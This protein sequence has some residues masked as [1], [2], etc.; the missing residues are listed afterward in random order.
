[1][2]KMRKLHILSLLLFSV[3]ISFA[4]ET[5]KDTLKTEVISV[6]KP[7]TPTISDAFKVT[8][9]PIIDGTNSFQKEKV[10]YTIFSIPVA[11]TFTPAKGTAQTV[12]RA[13]KERLYEN[14][15]SAG[16][17]NYTSPLFD[18]FVHYGDPKY[19]DFGVF[20]NYFSS[21]GGIKD[22][23]LN[24]NFSNA[25]ADIYY[26][27][28]ERGFDWK[29]NA[30]YKR[31]QTNYYGLPTDVIYD[32][33][34]L[35]SIDEKQVYNTIYF[36]GDINFDDSIFQ[37]G[38]IEFMNF[39][40]YYDSNE[41]RFFAKSNLEYP[42][43]T[44]IIKGEIL[45]DYV[46]GKFMHNY[47]NP[48]PI[49]YSF[50]TI[51]ANPSFEVLRTNLSVNLGVKL[52]YTFDM[53]NS[54]NQF[55]AYPNVTAS[56]QVVEDIFIVMAGV[57]GDLI[58][59][60]YKDF[61]EENPFVSPTLDILQ[62]DQQYKA[63]L[64]AKGKLASNIGYH[65]NANYSSEKD[66]PLYLQNQTLTNGIIPV[67]E[68]YQAGNSFKVVYDD[69]QT[70]NAFGELNFDAS[71]EINLALGINYANYNT[72]EQLKAWN[73]PEITATISGDYKAKNWYVGTKIFFNGETFDYVIPFAE[74]PENGTV[75]KNK[76]YIDLNFNG[77]YIFNDR[78][79][80]FVKLNNVLG[81][82]YNRFVNYPVQSIQVLGGI[83]YKFDLK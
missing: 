22:V 81:E 3:G 19:N 62:T 46:N 71:K 68:S 21:E 48:N 69:I 2:K 35:N 79:S 82:S 56:F 70:I 61:V 7:Y 43:S 83:T 75:V 65:F 47:F 53:E 15:V 54:T 27:Q 77:G 55:K 32:E 13:P 34:M 64:G 59:N 51:G 49:K 8:S 30:G 40:D 23:V 42:I 24:D 76:S 1:M 50:A 78:L 38:T 44:E 11:S 9:N 57:T 10:T 66:K 52:Y 31:F 28:Y 41:Y 20:L 25:K 45:V 33:M 36:G 14:Y 18:A 17:G 12:V 39:L 73:L 72:T 63:Y 26:K 29:I 37:G 6:V 16:F 4:Q 60:T 58:Q 74:L 5:K 67:N 80:A